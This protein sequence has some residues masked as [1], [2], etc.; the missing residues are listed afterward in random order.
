MKNYRYRAALAILL[1]LLGST[2]FAD[3]IGGN[4]PKPEPDAIISTR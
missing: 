2:A 1:A 3:P 4:P